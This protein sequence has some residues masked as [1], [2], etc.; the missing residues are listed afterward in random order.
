MCNPHR[1]YSV[2]LLLITPTMTR[3]KENSLMNRLPR[4]RSLAVLAC[5]ATVPALGASTV[6]TAAPTASAAR[7]CSGLPKYPG[8]GYFTSLKAEGLGC[9]SAKSQMLA[10]YRA[11]TKFKK[12]GYD[13]TVNGYKCSE[14][15]VQS[16]TD[17][18]SRVTCKDGS[19]TVIY[20]YQQEK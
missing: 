13:S 17:Y 10:H 11:R 12:T 6:A 15:R 4:A 20:T 18:N 3:T 14:R 8:V 19:K 2:Y 16:P 7:T 1:T 9:S 5:L